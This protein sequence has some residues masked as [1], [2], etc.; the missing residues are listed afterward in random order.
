M[1]YSRSFRPLSCETTNRRSRKL[2]SRIEKSSYVKMTSLQKLTR[3]WIASKTLL[4]QRL[5]HAVLCTLEML[6][7]RNLASQMHHQSRLLVPH[8]NRLW[9]NST[10]SS[11]MPLQMLKMWRA[12]LPSER[13]SFRTPLNFSVSRARAASQHKSHSVRMSCN[14]IGATYASSRTMGATLSRLRHENLKSKSGK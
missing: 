4:L 5:S 13:I 8:H 3:P 14:A 9:R 12:N 1:S 10:S 6:V 2:S 7:H 11:A